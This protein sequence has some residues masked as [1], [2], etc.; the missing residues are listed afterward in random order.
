MAM[1]TRLA[2]FWR[3]GFG[4][5]FLAAALILGVPHAVSAADAP[6]KT[7]SPSADP[8]DPAKMT[9]LNLPDM[10]MGKQDAPLNIVEY[11][12]MTCPHCAHFDMEIFP[13]L[14]KNYIDTGK[15]YYVFREFPL[16]G[17]ALRAS[18]VARCMDK[19]HFF[20]F[21]DKLFRKQIVWANPELWNDKKKSLEEKFTPLAEMAK[22]ESGMTRAD[23]DKC[24]A[25]K[26]LMEQIALQA[27][28]GT[29]VFNVPGTPA[30][31]LDGKLLIHTQTFDG[32]DADLKKALQGN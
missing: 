28:R 30:V 6:V 19:S 21:I 1:R 13:E 11:A 12:S 26:D 7:V 25:N 10:S 4:S 20:P 31:Y 32:I 22:A 27:K 8:D 18:M 2:L 14:K 9:V 3:W 16:D 24:L 17:V 5:A 23:F 15:V 29:D